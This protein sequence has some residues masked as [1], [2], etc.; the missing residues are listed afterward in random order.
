MKA[1]K[2][3]L[4]RSCK[5]NS[6]HRTRNRQLLSPRVI[7]NPPEASGAVSLDEPAEEDA[8][9]WLIHELETVFPGAEQLI[10]EMEL[11]VTYKDLTFETLNRKILP[12]VQ[13]AYPIL[14]WEK[15]Y[16][17][18]RAAGEKHLGQ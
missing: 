8:R 1:I 6:T 17:E 10:K 2:A 11:D 16:K 15:P 9:K 12:R 4:S 7:A 5:S 14:D 13:Q 3:N 18:F